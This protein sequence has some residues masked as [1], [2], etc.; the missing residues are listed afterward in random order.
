MHSEWQF[1]SSERLRRRLQPWEEAGLSSDRVD[2]GDY[3]LDWRSHGYGLRYVH[4]FSEDE[5]A[6]LAAECGFEVLETFLADGREG[7]LSIYQVWR[8]A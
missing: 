5:L 3:L 8:A 6:A 1:L 2:P 4:H 7:N